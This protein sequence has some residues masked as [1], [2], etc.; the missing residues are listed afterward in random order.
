MKANNNKD[1]HFHTVDMLFVIAL[2][3]TFAVSA[4]LLIAFGAN[5]YRNTLHSFDEHF[6]VAT[7]A[8][9]LKQKIRQHDIPGGVNVTEFG[10]GKALCLL[11]TINDRNYITY[12]YL[13]DGYIKEILVPEGADIVPESGH[14]IIE[15]SNL[16]INFVRDNIIWIGLG[17]MEDSYSDFV[18]LLESY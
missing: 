3:F 17:D 15:S 9:Y 5:T 16:D 14:N 12:I 13:K 7:A 4:S 18:L 8:S 11:D 1:R 10:D 2:F 6:T